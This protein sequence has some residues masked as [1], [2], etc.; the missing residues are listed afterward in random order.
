[1]IGLLHGV[2]LFMGDI[3]FVYSICGLVL[4]LCRKLEVRTFLVLAVLLVSFS[5]LGGAGIAV[6]DQLEFPSEGPEV[7]PDA[8]EIT[9]NNEGPLSSL[10]A[11]RGSYYAAWLFMSS[12]WFNWR[13]LG[14]FFLGAALMRHGFFAAE[15]ASLQRRIALF[16]LGIGAPLEVLGAWIGYSEPG[17]P[18]LA[19]FGAIHEPASLALA[20]G[21]MG[22]ACRLVYSGALRPVVRAFSSVGRL[23]LTNYIGQSVLANV[24]FSFVGLAWFGQR[25]RWE[26][27]GIVVAI[28]LAQ[29]AFSIVWMRT[30]R[31]GPLEWLWRSATYLRL[32]PIRR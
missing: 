10:I 1:M 18:L 29:I 9:V 13:V 16:G 17:I 20:L 19:T 27:I 22:L 32:Q 2:L 11:M 3:L 25:T 28:Y 31:V 30:F 12:L 5:M 21:Y 8:E 26:L 23:A 24:F 14:M 7:D 4:F 15:R 6:L